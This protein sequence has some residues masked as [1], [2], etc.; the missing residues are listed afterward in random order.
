MKRTDHEDIVDLMG[1][2]SRNG[3][4]SRAFFCIVT[5]GASEGMADRYIECQECGK[6]TRT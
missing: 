4:L 1:D 6:I 3:L 5:I 2:G